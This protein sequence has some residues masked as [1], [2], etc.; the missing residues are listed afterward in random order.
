MIAGR[1][2]AGGVGRSCQL[3]TAASYQW[4]S[5]SATSTS[6]V[7]V[8]VA[9]LRARAV[10]GKRPRARHHRHAEYQRITRLR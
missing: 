6:D 9:T 7:T 5:S 3:I 1:H 4:H 10:A 2:G 8:I